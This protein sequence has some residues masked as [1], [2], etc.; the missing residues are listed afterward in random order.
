MDR[1]IDAVARGRRLD[2]PGWVVAAVVV[3]V[4]AIV[5][6]AMLAT[7]VLRPNTEVWRQQ[8]RTRL[9]DQIVATLVLTVGVVVR[10]DRPRG[11]T[12]LAGQRPPRSP[13]GAC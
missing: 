8:W 11:G 13:G 9:P 1:P 4:L 2:R 10:L 7:S 3:A 12:G 6:I 5:P